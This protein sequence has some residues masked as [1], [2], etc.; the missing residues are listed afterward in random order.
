LDHEACVLEKEFV[1]EQECVI[2]S[3]AKQSVF[4]ENFC[5]DNFLK[6]GLLRFARNDTLAGNGTF[7]TEAVL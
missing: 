3:E 4:M 7:F 2:A 6:D 5:G 1:I